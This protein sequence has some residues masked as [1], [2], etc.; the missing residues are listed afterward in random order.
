MIFLMIT[1]LDL[2]LICPENNFNDKYALRHVTIYSHV[3]I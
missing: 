3:L 2:K 1:F